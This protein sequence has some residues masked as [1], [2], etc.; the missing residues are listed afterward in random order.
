MQQPE[1]LFMALICPSVDEVRCAQETIVGIETRYGFAFDARDLRLQQLWI[2]RADDPACYLVLKLEDIIE[3]AL[4]AVGPQ[5]APVV[6]SINCPV[7]RTRFPDFRTLPSS[8]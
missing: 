5:C 7:M 8:R 1:R 3:R 6:V 2:Y 4:E